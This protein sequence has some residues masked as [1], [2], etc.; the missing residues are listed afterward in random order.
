MKIL[1]ELSLGKIGDVQKIT[2]EIEERNSCIERE[3]EAY[4]K[5]EREKAN[6][7]FRSSSSFY[8]FNS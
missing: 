2:I 1:N 8:M 3:Q 7:C 5:M 6:V 4:E